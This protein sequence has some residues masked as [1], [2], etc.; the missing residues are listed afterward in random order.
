MI[1][2][3][4]ANLTLEETQEQCNLQQADT[5]QLTAIAVGTKVDPETGQVFMVNNCTF[6]IVQEGLPKNLLFAKAGTN[7]GG[8]KLFDCKMY[9]ENHVNDV[10]VFGE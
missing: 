6:E 4:A 10:S 8:E 2:P 3:I 9:V 5:F 7:P 1:V